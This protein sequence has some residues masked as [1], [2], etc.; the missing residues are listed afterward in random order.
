MKNI[1]IIGHFGGSKEFYDG[2]TVKTRNLYNELQRVVA[3]PI[4]IVDTYEKEKHPIKLLIKTFYAMMTCKHIF[5]LVSGNGMRVFFPLLSIGSKLFNINVFNDVIGGRLGYFLDKHKKYITYLNSFTYNIVETEL[6]A[7]ELIERGITN[8]EIIPNFRRMEAIEHHQLREEF[9]EP[10]PFCTFSR[11]TKEK[12]IGEAIEAIELLNQQCGKI[13]AT[14]DIYG[15]I[16]KEYQQEFEELLTLSSP[17]IQYKGRV[18]SETAIETLKN[19]Y[20]VLFPTFWEGESNAG[21]ISESFFAGVPVI[22]TD[23]NCNKEMIINGYNGMLYPSDTAATLLDGIKWLI[24][25][26]DQMTKIKMNCLESSK[27]YLPDQHIKRLVEL[28]NI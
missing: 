1:A 5:V 26:K 13:C 18:P 3:N 23:W 8:V 24:S 20:G 6:L 11:V 9:Q 17:A 22:A 16:E 4:T 25:Q 21:T 10:L 14:L 19:Y 27:Y 2:Q 28:L 12:G 15:T 7:K